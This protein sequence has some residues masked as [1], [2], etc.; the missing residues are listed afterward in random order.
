MSSGP[1]FI[2]SVIR[3][4]IASLVP[5][6]LADHPY[7]LTARQRPLDEGGAVDDA[8]G[9]RA[10]SVVPRSDAEW[11]DAMWNG[12]AGTCRQTFQIW[13]RYRLPP[14]GIGAYSVHDLVAE[15]AAHISQHLRSRVRWPD[16]PSVTRC[17][18]DG[19]TDTTSDAGGSV[20]TRLDMVI[21]HAMGGED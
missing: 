6:V 14:E 5:S 17:Q 7:R 19:A 18:Q 21:T 1:A 20:I 15:D 9:L 2:A 4:K 8:E 13:L 10:V 3:T 16:A 11:D 12:T